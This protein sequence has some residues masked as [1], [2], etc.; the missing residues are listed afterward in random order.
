MIF[1]SIFIY[2]VP[3]DDFRHTPARR[4]PNWQR[5]SPNKKHCVNSG[6]RCES[7]T[8]VTDSGDRI[9]WSLPGT[10]SMGCTF[11]SV[12]LRIRLL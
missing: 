3:E 9:I 11:L 8:R 1:S 10:I 4:W 5:V 6:R 2:A 7:G 12:S